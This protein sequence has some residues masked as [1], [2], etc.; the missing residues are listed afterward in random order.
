M[1]YSLAIMV[2]CGMILSG[3]M[4]KLKL[5]GLVGM[6]L[7]GIVLG[8]NALNLIAPELLNVSADLRQIA[9]IVILTRAGL[10]LDIKDL[11][12]VGRPAI[13]MCFI[14][15]TFE[16][17]ATTIFAPMFFPVS[18]LEAAI[19]GTVLGAV[20]PAVI[21]PKM[22]K[23]M[24]HGYGR[25]KSIP[26]L[27]MAGA[28]V[29]DIYVIVL[30]T[31]F[32]GMYQGS[33]F[34]AVSLF[35]IPAAIVT[36][37]MAGILLG[38]V[39]VM[40]FQRIHMRDTAKILILLSTAFL[41]ISLETA[42]KKYVPM[43]GLLAV[44]S[45]GGTILKKNDILAK[46]LSG[47]FSKIWVAAELMLFILVGATVDISYA[48]KAGFMAVALIFL[49]LA[50]R[51]C[52]VFVCLVKTPI[53]PKE[54]LFCAIAYLP[55]ATVQAAIGGLP[56]AAGVAAGN[57]ILTVAVLAILITA[58]LGAMGVDSTYQRLLAGNDVQGKF[59]MPDK[60]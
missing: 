31:S 39:L 36:G 23:L 29:D 37:L 2:L 3:T 4:Q 55:K 54:R 8:P 15:A 22:L 14:P 21:V 51:I 50:I 43:S 40:L 60:Q 57:T 13:L 35:K 16:I 27:I 53:S 52:G 6:L 42:I 59:P 46:R 58:P 10:A 19:M 38:L 11:K 45:L 30:F 47:K 20:S 41:L 44:M 25:E 18:H 17:T 12:R 9:L 7:T 5:P 26:Q 34:D 32:M 24:E 49:A 48:A 1:L 33:S 56:L 28:S